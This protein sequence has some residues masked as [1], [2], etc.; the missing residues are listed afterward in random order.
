MAENGTACD[1]Y[2]ESSVYVSA[3]IQGYLERK[4]GVL[5][6][7][8]KQWCSL[9]GLTLYLQK[10]QRDVI[11]T[12]DLTDV[13]QVRKVTNENT[14]THFEICM[15]KKNH[16]FICPSSED[17][18]A[19]IQALQIAISRKNVSQ[20]SSS[21]LTG[22]ATITDDKNVYNEI[23]EA[24]IRESCVQ[25]VNLLD[26]QPCVPAN[27]SDYSEPTDIESGT[28]KCNSDYWEVGDV[29]NIL[30]QS[31]SGSVYDACA[32][33]T[34]YA[35]IDQCCV[36]GL[37]EAT[38]NRESTVVY[39]QVNK[40]KKSTLLTRSSVS[41][42]DIAQVGDSEYEYLTSC[43][44]VN[45]LVEKQCTSHEDN[46]FTLP[47]NLQMK[48]RPQIEEDGNVCQV[49]V[50]ALT[51]SGCSSFDFIHPLTEEDRKPL[52]ELTEFLRKNHEICRASFS[53]SSTNSD[54][55]STLKSY[56]ASL[57]ISM[58]Q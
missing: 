19:W 32:F 48:K 44:T 4:K 37:S 10:K 46:N 47:E 15:K 28:R 14:G 8:T 45:N 57:D 22:E 5:G 9:Q 52:K 58:R 50:D 26:T 3:E 17:C 27:F 55:V 56:L 20:Q 49:L 12:I 38:E 11:E 21:F 30:R 29:K 16:V 41:E 18:M 43:V 53:C 36:N 42:N 40:T 39:S 23:D 6:V 2:R 24:L 13:L 33:S 51:D 31:S 34:T 7:K 1:I 35:T 54:P 25:T